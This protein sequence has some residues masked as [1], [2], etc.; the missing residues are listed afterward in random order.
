MLY[1]DAVNRKTNQSN[2]GTIK[3][4]NLCTKIVQF[5][6]ETETSVCNLASVALKECVRCFEDKPAEFD[7]EELHKVIK[8]MTRNLNN[9]IDLNYYPV[10]TARNSNMKHRPIGLGVQG[11]ASGLGVSLVLLLHL[12]PSADLDL[13]V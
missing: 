13:C 6:S 9:V 4:S 1:K 7:F 12:L 8:V 5:S 11:A 3:S 2:L 10:E